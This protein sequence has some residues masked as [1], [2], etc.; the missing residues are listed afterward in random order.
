MN[1]CVQQTCAFCCPWTGFSSYHFFENEFHNEI[2][3]EPVTCIYLGIRRSIWA[4]LSQ[5]TARSLHYFGRT[6]LV[7][8]VFKPFYCYL[9]RIQNIKQSISCFICHVRPNGKSDHVSGNSTV[10]FQMA[11]QSPRPSIETPLLLYF[12]ICYLKLLLRVYPL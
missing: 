2:H 4:N 6:S 11:I 8:L 10:H 1:D 7:S 5:N 3:N 9:R 12:R